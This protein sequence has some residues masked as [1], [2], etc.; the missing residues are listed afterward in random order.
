MS[1]GIRKAVKQSGRAGNRP[2]HP[3]IAVYT[4]H[5][6]LP[7]PTIIGVKK[8]I[9]IDDRQSREKAHCEPHVSSVKYKMN[10]KYIIYS[11]ISSSMIS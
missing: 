6:T 5:L 9:E 11:R 2:T 3:L 1:W 7:F 4:L 8:K 10:D